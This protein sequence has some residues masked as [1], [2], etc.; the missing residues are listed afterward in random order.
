MRPFGSWQPGCQAG[1]QSASC[2]A[3]GTRLARPPPAPNGADEAVLISNGNQVA[4]QE[5]R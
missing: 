1:R 4:T 3:V 2:N 5:G